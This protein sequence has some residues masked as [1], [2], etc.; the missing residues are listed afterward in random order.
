MSA[1]NPGRIPPSASPRSSPSLLEFARA[2][3]WLGVIGF[4]GGYSV[5]VQVRDLMVTRWGWLTEREFANTATVAQMLPGGAA[6][7]ALT[8]VGLRFFRQRG[9]AIAYALFILPGLATVW[10]LAWAYVRFG[11]KAPSALTV[12]EGFNAAVVGIIASLTIRMVR[13]AVARAWQMAV[14][15]GALLLSIGGGASAGE[16]AM[17]GIGAGLAIDLG[18]KRARLS[19]VRRAPRRPYKPPPPVALPDEG[20]PLPRGNEPPHPPGRPPPGPRLALLPLG[21]LPAT[22]ASGALAGIALTL[23]RTGLAAY[24]GGFAIIPY[25]QATLVE[26]QH[27]LTP[28]VF[29][30]AVAIGKL[31]PGPVLL[32]GTFIGYVLRGPLGAAVATVAIFSGPYL[33]VV[34]LGTWLIRLRSR[35]PVRAA[36]RGLTPAV[37]GLMGAAAV[38]LGTGLVDAADVAIASAVTLTM[39]RF[40]PNAAMVLLLG[41]LARLGM[42]LAGF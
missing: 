13:T 3:L 26:S 31:T 32:L 22:V 4:G 37:V 19:R 33:L 38:T 21:G 6:A 25:L 7:N 2:C 35:R 1:S 18:I 14:A 12:L 36:L 29:A 8:L 5:L 10:V 17:L 11:V 16:V 42:K 30:D 40:R 39:V 24:G 34:G 15:A 20:E 27:V 41:G 23:F 28:R 9:A